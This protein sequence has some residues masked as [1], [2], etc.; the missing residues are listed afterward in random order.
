MANG[1]LFYA[2]G[3]TEYLC[4]PPTSQMSTSI[5]KGRFFVETKF[6]TV[7]I[8]IGCSKVSYF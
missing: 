6:K 8:L 5:F 7:N 1:L 4:L 3:K 2:L